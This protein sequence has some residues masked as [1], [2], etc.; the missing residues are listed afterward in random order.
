MNDTNEITSRRRALKLAGILLA[1]LLVFPGISEARIWTDIYGRQVEADLVEI[2]DGGS[3]V[4]LRV[5]DGKLFRIPVSTLSEAD[6]R[7]ISNQGGGANPGGGNPVGSG[8][9]PHGKE[10]SAIRQ[11][12]RKLEVWLRRAMREGNRQSVRKLRSG[13]KRLKKQLGAL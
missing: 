6:R 8:S 11:Q 12:I 1:N 3:A 10:K 2:H 7:Y 9:D 5:L 4:T 13:I